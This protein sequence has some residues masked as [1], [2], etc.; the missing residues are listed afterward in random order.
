M[1]VASQPIRAARLGGYAELAAEVRQLGLMNRRPVF[2][3]GLLGVVLLALGT[4]VA[5][6]LM[7]HDTWSALLF[8]PVFA[9]VS[10]QL[11]FFGHDAAHRQISRRERASRMVGLFSANLLNGLSYG[12]WL[13][14]HNAHHAHPNDLDADPDVYAGAVVFDKGQAV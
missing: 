2:Y 8:A 6:L 3:A 4:S 11:G 5:G 13:D 1:S 10:A 7:L 9:V 12:W 14:K